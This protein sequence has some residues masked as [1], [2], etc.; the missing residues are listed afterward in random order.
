[1]KK[2]ILKGKTL[3]EVNKGNPMVME[4]HYNEMKLKCDL[5]DIRTKEK[6]DW[7]KKLQSK[8]LA[9]HNLGGGGYRGKEKIWAREDAEYAA[10]GIQNPWHRNEHL[11]ARAV[12]RSKYHWDPKTKQ[13]TI[14][15]KVKK[16][17]EVLLAKEKA[18]RTL[19]S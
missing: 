13:L 8:N 11:V 14:D 9:A 2:E 19:S 6:S 7:G 3:E 16:F 15:P 5:N 18:S 17:E 10:K 4:A 12:I 1:V